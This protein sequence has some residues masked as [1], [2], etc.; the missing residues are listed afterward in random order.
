MKRLFFYILFLFSFL[1]ATD[2]MSVSDTLLSQTPAPTKVTQYIMDFAGVLK[3]AQKS[4]LT[5]KLKAF[6]DSTSNQVIVYIV[7]SLNGKSIEDYSYE[8]AEKNK[9]GHKGKDNGVLLLIAIDDRKMRIEV[10]YGLEGVL[11]DALS[12]SIIR[13]EISPSFK[14]GD[15]YGGIEKGL[16]AIFLATKNEYKAEKEKTIPERIGFVAV[17]FV[18]MFFL[19]AF[20]QFIKGILGFGSVSTGNKRS[21]WHGSGGWF[22]GGGGFGG[23]GGGSSG[24]FGGGGFTGGG[25]SFGGGGASGSW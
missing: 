21:G 8:V 3:P 1:S 13:N 10:G 25:G 22:I 11:T 14:K 24:G 16:N 6:E 5:Q 23:F 9:V 19:L 18:L 17:F 20:I 7:N 4:Y 12:S 2:A 15:Y